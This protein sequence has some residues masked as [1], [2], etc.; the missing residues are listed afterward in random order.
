MKWTSLTVVVLF[1][2]S[3][4][5]SFLT[6]F[7]S[8]LVVQIFNTYDINTV[9]VNTAFLCWI[10]FV[11]RGYYIMN[12]TACV[13]YFLLACLAHRCV[14][15]RV[16]PDGHVSKH[17]HTCSVYISASL[18]STDLNVLLSLSNRPPFRQREYTSAASVV[19]AS[20]LLIAGIEQ[21][22]GPRI[23]SCTPVQF[24]LLNSRSAVRKAAAIH[25]AIA[26]H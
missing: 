20:L 7:L 11:V 17:G 5:L 22:P 15:G 16:E 23:G 6:L 12:L 1:L 26:D 25:D 21:N 9:N 2:A 10:I 4:I 19:V 13:T 14:N 24:G 18:T 8:S 3:S